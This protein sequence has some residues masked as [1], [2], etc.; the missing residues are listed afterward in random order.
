MK[1][2]FK[3]VAIFA[4]VTLC[5]H[6]FNCLHS[7]VHAQDIF[8]GDSDPAILFNDIDGPG[9][10]WVINTDGGDAMTTTNVFDLLT[11]NDN[12]AS[13]ENV[14]NIT[15][16]A[17]GNTNNS[18]VVE[19]DGDLQLANG[20]V[21]V[22]RS[23]NRVGLGTNNPSSAL[24]VQSLDPQIRVQNTATADVEK[25]MM[26][27]ENKGGVNFKLHDQSVPGTQGEWTFRTGRDGSVFVIG[28]TGSGV[29][30]MESQSG[31]NLKI[32]G[33]LMQG[34]SRA[35]KENIAQID[36]QEILVKVSQLPINEWNY[37]H[38]QDNVKHIGPMA[39]DFHR[40]F[41]VGNGPKTISS[42][43]TSGVA[44]AA[45]KA[46]K[47]KLDEKDVEL[48]ELRQQVAML[49]KQQQRMIAVESMVSSL[50]ARQKSTIVAAALVQ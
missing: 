20:D 16:E 38:D 26:R 23:A 5:P 6:F 3:A 19:V 42:L 46:L 18:L 37:V 31:G 30:E 45:I 33:N 36:V 8:I 44:F 7:D 35:K 48:T 41:Q 50:M 34:S 21:F 1:K 10:S 4:G 11:S 29:V 32:A 27:L 43:D 40:L 49:Q 13:T 17:D 39:E 12:G 9:L 25:V 22:D 47:H 28:K 2:L 14:I 15:S 24:H